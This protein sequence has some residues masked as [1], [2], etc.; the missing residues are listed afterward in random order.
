MALYTEEAVTIK[1]R[2][3]NEPIDKLQSF[4]VIVD[5]IKRKLAKKMFYID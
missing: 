3:F 2:F 1:L 4:T 5:A